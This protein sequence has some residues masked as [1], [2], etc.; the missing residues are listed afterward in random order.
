MC[1]TEH[2]AVD[3]WLAVRFLLHGSYCNL[4]PPGQWS[5][6][7][8]LTERPRADRAADGPKPCRFRVKL[9]HIVE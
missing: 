2:P 4:D 5:R 3:V 8:G 9:S 7:P 1:A 6:R